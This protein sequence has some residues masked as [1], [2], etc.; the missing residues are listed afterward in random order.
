M[1]SILINAERSYS[2]ILTSD[3][4][5]ELAQLCVGR[6]RVA[7]IVSESFKPDFSRLLDLD[8]DIHV[9]DVPDGEDAKN[10]TTLNKVWNWL[11]A[12]GFTRSDLIVGIGGGAITDLAGFAAATW[13][14]GLDWIAVPTS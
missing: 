7:V 1:T 11:G 4:N 3:W 5:I 9:F 13:L 12:T 6:N 14:R 2:V 10:I 8:A